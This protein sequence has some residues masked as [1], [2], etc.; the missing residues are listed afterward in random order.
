MKTYKIIAIDDSYVYAKKYIWSK[1]EIFLY[2][3]FSYND[4]CEGKLKVGDKVKIV[5]CVEPN[6]SYFSISKIN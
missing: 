1:R 2:C 3:P 4:M 5:Q 6:T